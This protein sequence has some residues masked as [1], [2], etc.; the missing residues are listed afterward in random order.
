MLLK[1]PFDNGVMWSI[2]N[3][4]WGSS[5]IP[6][7]HEQHLK[8]SRSLISVLNLEVIKAL[9]PA[10]DLRH[11]M[12]SF[13]KWINRFKFSSSSLITHSDELFPPA[14]TYLNV[15][16]GIYLRWNCNIRCSFCSIYQNL[17]NKPLKLS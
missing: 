14:E 12:A 9:C 2:S 1:P 6:I 10:T 15:K 8:L 5:S 4:R 11:L 3:N 16:I 13:R 7:L 17:K